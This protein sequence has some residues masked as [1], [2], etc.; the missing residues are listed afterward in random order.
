MSPRLLSFLSEIETALGAVEPAPQ[1]GSWQSTRM[2]NNCLGLARLHLSAR[3]GNET[4]HP[5]GAVQLQAH[6]LADG[7]QCLKAFLSWNGRDSEAVY[8]IY[9]NPRLNWR[10][11]ARRLA[12]AWLQGQAAASEIYE[13]LAAAG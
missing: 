2:V 13:P 4:L 8:A 3:L 10:L 7:T 6:R 1:G 11:E 5:L 12:D 9:D